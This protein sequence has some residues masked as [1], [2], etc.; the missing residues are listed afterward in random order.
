[1]EIIV[2][3]LRLF[4][5]SLRLVRRV[6][7][8]LCRLH[9]QL[10]HS[11]MNGKTR[12][13]TGGTCFRCCP[14]RWRRIGLSSSIPRPPISG[15]SELTDALDELRIRIVVIAITIARVRIN[16]RRRSGFPWWWL[17]RFSLLDDL[18][19]HDFLERGLLRAG[20]VNRQLT[21]YE[22]VCTLRVRPNALD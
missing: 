2:P 20:F 21:Q 14:L 4:P 22:L 18:G 5:P 3:Y 9:A 8:P 15:N 6:L 1:M 17:H 11:L 12:C 7:L 19:A 10:M 16:V 13:K